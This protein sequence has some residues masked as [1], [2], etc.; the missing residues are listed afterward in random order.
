MSP[1][2]IKQSGYDFKADIWSLG[3]TAIELAKGEP[4]YADLHPMKVLFLIP[5]NPPPTLEGDFSKPFKDFV[6]ECL[7]RDPN[8]RPTARDLLK[9]RFIRN[10]KKTSYLTEL[11]ERLEQWKSSGAGKR[12]Q[13]E[14]AADDEDDDGPEP[15]TNYWEFGTV[16]KGTTRRVPGAAPHQVSQP[17]PAPAVASRDY[18]QRSVP[19][20]H[21]AFDTVRHASVSPPTSHAPNPQQVAGR[22]PPGP[23]A[24]RPASPTGSA[25]SGKETRFAGQIGNGRGSVRAKHAPSPPSASNH[26]GHAAQRSEASTRTTTVHE[27]DEEDAGEIL[28]TVVIP[29]LQSVRA[30]PHLAD[31]SADCTFFPDPEPG[32]R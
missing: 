17:A 6:S 27:D 13:E 5:K 9:H 14:D 8:A 24:R 22:G 3:I 16:R 32:L 20:G 31:R 19:G 10:A 25:T 1:E 28:D 4:P 26:A 12:R 15:D 21:V 30:H 18:A 29:V 2:V 7:R 23:G 11:I